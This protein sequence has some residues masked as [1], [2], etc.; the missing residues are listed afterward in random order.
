MTQITPAP[1]LENNLSRRKENEGD[2]ND[3]NAIRRYVKEN[4]SGPENSSIDVKPLWDNF[5]RINYWR[6]T[7]STNS[8]LTEGK[9]IHSIFIKIIKVPDGYFGEEIVEANTKKNFIK[10]IQNIKNIDQCKSL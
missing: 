6:E 10:D 2:P 5:Y 4:F 7:N 8:F 3:I 1:N 9:I